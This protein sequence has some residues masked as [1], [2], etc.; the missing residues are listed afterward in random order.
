VT[1]KDAFDVWWYRAE[2]PHESMLTMP[3]ELHEAVMALSPEERRD[4]E[5]VNEAARQAEESRDD[6]GR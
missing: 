3:A 6:P 2:K 5:K 1:T 4:R